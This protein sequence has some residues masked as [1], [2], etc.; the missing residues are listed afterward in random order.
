[1]YYYYLQQKETQGCLLVSSSEAGQG[2]KL[3]G[4]DG[5]VGVW[6][7]DIHQYHVAK[8]S[9]MHPQ[10]QQSDT[11]QRSPN[12]SPLYQYG[13]WSR[14]WWWYLCQSIQPHFQN[15]LLMFC[16]TPS[17]LKSHLEGLSCSAA[18]L[19]HHSLIH[20]Q[21]LMHGAMSAPWA[22]ESQDTGSS[23]SYT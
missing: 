2:R 22:E 6:P 3:T 12:L 8:L 18:L 1:M 13:G 19:D 15:W 11:Y 21:V 7:P 9:G 20:I 10:N 5:H 4:V 17:T 16:W 14:G 23:S